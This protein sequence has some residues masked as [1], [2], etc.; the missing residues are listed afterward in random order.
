MRR[1]KFIYNEK[2]LQ[3]EKHKASTQEKVF[4]SIGVIC[5]VLFTAFILNFV[6]SE[7][8]PSS[9][10][11]A[12]TR[13]IN[14]MQTQYQGMNMQLE[15][16]TSVLS[17]IQERDATVHRFM[18]GMD[19]IDNAMWEGGVGGHEQFKN[20]VMYKN[21][22]SMLVNTKQKVSQLERQIYL[23]SKSLD[24]LEVLASAKED[25]I[26][27]IPSI[28]P[29]REDKLKRQIRSLS[30]FGK[31]MHPV[32]KVIKMH[33]GIDFTCPT[34]TAI[35]ST[36]KGKVVAVKKSRTGYGNHVI[37]DH[38]YGYKTLY[39]H[40]NEVHVKV[41]QELIKGEQ[42]GTVGNTGTS[43]APHL[44]YEVR[45]KDKPVNPIHYV[46]DGLSPQEYEELV[47]KAS[48]ANQSFD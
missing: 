32:H 44:H 46:I 48:I 25:M 17:N 34:G 4:R 29:V 27:S 12:L 31:R 9:K 24:T 26:A 10:E 38:G 43:T 45:F 19:P 40:L 8:F 14:Q 15:R 7:Y 41:G 11:L 3:Y 2:T 6:R 1:E 42:I 37:I 28:K 35:Q 30:G 18:F 20:L 36:G 22:G 47:K 13:E 5:S 39:G 33:T 21:S 16:M 23:Q